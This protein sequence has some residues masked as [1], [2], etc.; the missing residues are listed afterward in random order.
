MDARALKFFK[1]AYLSRIQESKRL[2]RGHEPR[3]SANPMD[4]GSQIVWR[5]ELHD[6]L[7]SREVKASSGDVC[8]EQHIL[9][10]LFVVKV[11]GHSFGLRL[12]SVQFR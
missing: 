11:N 1:K 6:P 4:I 2:S 9:F 3:R 5:V 7:D 8:R 10:V 12:S